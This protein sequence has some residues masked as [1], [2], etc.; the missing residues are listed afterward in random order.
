MLRAVRH[1]GGVLHE[2]VAGARAGAQAAAQDGKATPPTLPL[3]LAT[4]EDSSAWLETV[5]LR[6]GRRRAA[7]GAAGSSSCLLK[8]CALAPTRSGGGLSSHC[9][10]KMGPWISPELRDCR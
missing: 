4:A 10:A 6:V 7:E 3:L 8:Y 1:S 2:N 9:R 5:E